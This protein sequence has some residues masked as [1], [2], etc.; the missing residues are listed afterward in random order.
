[1]VLE[2]RLFA[3][4]RPFSPLFEADFCVQFKE[5][6]RFGTQRFISIK[7]TNDHATDPPMEGN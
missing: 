3:F 1:M 7:K 2:Q 4:V 6:P 5:I